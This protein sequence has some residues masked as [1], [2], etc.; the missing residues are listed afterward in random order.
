MRLLNKDRFSYFFGKDTG[1]LF[2]V[3]PGE[4]F[5]VETRDCYVDKIKKPDDLENSEIFDF[6]MSH[7]NP[8][9][10]PIYIKGAEPGDVIKVHLKEIKL[11]NQVTTCIGAAMGEDPH[12]IFP[13]CKA[14]IYEVYEGKIMMNRDI[15]LPIDP[16][17][18]T[19]GVAPKH[20]CISSEKQ[21]NFGGNIDCQDVKIGSTLWLPV[22]IEGALLS[23]GDVHALQGD[24]EVGTPFEAAATVTLSVD[25]VKGYSKN[26][27]W[28]RVENEKN[29]ATI[30]SSK[31]F[32]K[33]AIEAHRE[34]M[35]WLQEEYNFN[36]VDAYVFL[37][38]VAHTRVCQ[39][40]CQQ[41]TVRCVLPK[42]FLPQK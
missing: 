42:K 40:V 10:G 34:M 33:A 25:I 13:I 6:I 31:T 26:M 22:F 7:Q 12:R 1:E 14:L 23:L 29:I 35:Y 30:V 2:Y 3:E 11:A 39:F 24:G 28:P 32:E 27:K 36:E 20:E 21:G 19:I 5:S 16:L 8:V 15:S 37:N 9:S 17:V 4:I 41:V 18:G 38:M